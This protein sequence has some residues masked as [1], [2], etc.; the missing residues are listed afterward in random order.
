MARAPVSKTGGW[1]FESLHSCQ[2]KVFYRQR[3]SRRRL[4]GLA[5]ASSLLALAGQA[6][7]SQAS[8]TIKFVVPFPAGGA[9]DLLTRVLTQQIGTSG[10]V[11][12]VVENRPGAASIVGT[13][14]VSRAAPDGNTLLTAA[15]SF[16]IHPFF[17]QLNY[18]PLTSFAPI[19]WLANSPQAIVVNSTSPYHSLDD[20]IGAARAKPGQLTNAG[21]GPATTQ[22]I[23][24]EL[25]KLRANINM[26]YVPFNGNGPAINELLGGHVDTV[27]ANYSEVSENVKAGNLRALAVG[28]RTR[29]Q[30][31][32]DVPT[33]AESGYAGYEVYVW[34]GLFAP[35]G[36]PAAVVDQLSQWADAAMLAPELKPKWDLQGIDPVGKPSADLAAHIR[37]QQE[38]YGR[39][40]HEANIQGE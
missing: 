37:Q 17:K 28:S 5:G 9:A 21:V 31:M 12:T 39:V 27:M 40:I 14:Y 15:N 16:I 20:L 8:R 10:G 1:G 22:H 4:I 34:F 18:D 24:F 3:V 33:V 35:A 25:L 32:P 30:W 29:L 36:T 38:E 2:A 11:T 6:A 23:A 13:E 26:I 19:S 7:W